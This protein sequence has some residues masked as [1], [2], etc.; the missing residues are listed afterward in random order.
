MKAAF[1]DRDGTISEEYPDDVWPTI[2]RPVLRSRTVEGLRLLR[3]LDYEIFIVT[4]QPLIGAGVLTMDQYEAY[5]R[6]LLASLERNGVT[7]REILM[8]PHTK[9]MGCRC[10]KPR[11]GLIESAVARHASI[12]LKQSFVVGDRQSD[13]QLAAAFGMRGFSVG[14]D[15][16]GA[17]RVETILD[18]AR[19]LRSAYKSAATASAGRRVL[20]R[21]PEQASLR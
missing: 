18:V 17:V 21:R 13:M 10:C 9:E 11:P 20:T 12:D 14:F 15:V 19:T 16:E 2:T 1:C 4:N 5:T 8:C 7:V 3:D 6:D